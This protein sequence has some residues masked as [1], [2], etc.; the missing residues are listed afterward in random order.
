[1][2]LFIYNPSHPIR[3]LHSNSLSHLLTNIYF[4]FFF[5]LFVPSF[6]FTSFS[7][8]PT[9][10]SCTAKRETPCRTWRRCCGSPMAPCQ[11]SCWKLWPS[12]PCSIRPTS[13]SASHSRPTVFLFSVSHQCPTPLLPLPAR[14][15]MHRRVFATPWR[16]CKAWQHT[17]TPA[18][19]FFTVSFTPF[20][21]FSS[22]PF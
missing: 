15:L 20:F 12:I 10:F 9:L 19:T 3:L 21:L 5:S 18:T 1:M 6:F 17:T 2:F 7:P 13:R 4:R 14:R 22:Q 16:S 11:H 8:F